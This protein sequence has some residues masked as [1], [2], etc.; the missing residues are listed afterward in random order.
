M[1]DNHFEKHAQLFIGT[2]IPLISFSVA[3]KLQDPWFITDTITHQSNKECNQ[4]DFI[5]M[6]KTVYCVSSF[7][8]HLIGN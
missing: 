2:Y 1:Q 3:L 7:S 5:W 4:F 6:D 8:C